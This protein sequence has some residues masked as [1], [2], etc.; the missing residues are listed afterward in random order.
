MKNKFSFAHLLG[1]NK[2]AKASRAEEEEEEQNAEEEEENEEG[3][4][5]SSKKGKK[6]KKANEDDPD[7]EEDDPDAEEDD[8]DAE[9][10]GDDPD[11][12]ED[13]E[14]ENKDVKKGRKAERE[15]CAAIFSSRHAAG[16]PD[17]AATL[18]FTTKLSAKE[19]I[20]VMRAN[21]RTVMGAAVQLGQPKRQ[22]LQERM[23]NE[24]HPKIGVNGGKSGGSTAEKMMSLY[25]R[26]T[27]SDKK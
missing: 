20:R 17:L 25:N 1:L 27:G 24:P 7:A 4:D 8:P 16:R 5:K 22:T 2:A 6:A 10:D 13:E 18:A 19:A 15:R 23:A 3:D 21:G 14:D 12:E 26:T 9:D 11:A